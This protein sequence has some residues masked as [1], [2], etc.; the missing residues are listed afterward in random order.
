MTDATAPLEDQGE[1]IASNTIAFRRWQHDAPVSFTVSARDENQTALLRTAILA[2]VSVAILCVALFLVPR[3]A[4]A[5]DAYTL[6]KVTMYQPLKGQTDGDP[7]SG[8]FARQLKRKMRKGDIG[9]S[10]DLLVRWR[11]VFK[12][13]D[14]V[15]LTASAGSDPRC[16]GVFTVAD[17]MNA[18]WRRKAD[19]FVLPSETAVNCYR[20]LLERV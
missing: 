8:A 9:L 10:R 3:V 4:S 6:P 13:G 5:H 16:T 2:A 18:R 1:M 11:G 7:W 20:V 17:V 15:R 14:Q 19:I 12:A